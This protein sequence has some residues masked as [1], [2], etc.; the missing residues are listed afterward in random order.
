MPSEFEINIFRRAGR[1]EK[2]TGALPRFET[3]GEV[4]NAL[5]E[6]LPVLSML[7]KIFPRAPNTETTASEF[8]EDL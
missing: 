6:D 8:M 1:K 2:A 7:H 5:Y 3:K 4:E